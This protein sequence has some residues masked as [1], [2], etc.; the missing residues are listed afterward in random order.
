M[1]DPASRCQ[2][3]KTQLRMA[4]KI[5]SSTINQETGK[6]TRCGMLLGGGEDFNQRFLL[7]G[8]AN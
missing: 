7:L 3:G 8:V 6:G 4:L 2:Y 5:G 1:T